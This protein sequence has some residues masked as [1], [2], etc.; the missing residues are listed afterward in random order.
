M[1]TSSDLLRFVGDDKV[2]NNN[3]KFGFTHKFV[4]YTVTTVFCFNII[5][6]FGLFVMLGF[7]IVE[8]SDAAVAALGSVTIALMGLMTTLLK[9]IGK[10]GLHG[11]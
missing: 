5:A 1:N 10:N 7:G 9:V 2:R 11:I 6:S 8:M 3:S 4:I